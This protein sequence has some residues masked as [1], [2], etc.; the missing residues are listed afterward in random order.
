MSKPQTPPPP[1][2]KEQTRVG[3][4]SPRPSEVPY[5]NGTPGYSRNA[6]AQCIQNNTPTVELGVNVATKETGQFQA[7]D[8][9][10]CNRNG[11]SVPTRHAPFNNSLAIARNFLP[12]VP[13]TRR[14]APP[15]TTNPGGR[16]SATHASFEPRDANNSGKH[17]RD[18]SPP[19]ISTPILQFRRCPH[20]ICDYIPCPLAQ[21]PGGLG[22]RALW[23]FPPPQT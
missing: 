8:T 16:P 6:T 14:C 15:N 9:R 11:P 19:A 2:Q 17:A 3:E 1:P 23:P 21:S 7:R 20:A 4:A 5:A 18:V 12:R 22:R 13:A 10:P